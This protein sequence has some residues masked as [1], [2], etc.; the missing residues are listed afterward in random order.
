M[1]TLIPYI[2]KG[3]IIIDG[4]NSFFMDTIRRSKELEDLGFKFIC[5]GICTYESCINGV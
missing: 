4:G 1:E 5:T 3:D 2:S